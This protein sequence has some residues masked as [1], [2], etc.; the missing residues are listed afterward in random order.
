ME[1]LRQIDTLEER[2]GPTALVMSLRG[3]ALLGIEQPAP[4]ADA[5]ARALDIA[6]RDVACHQG[7]ARARRALGEIARARKHE[8]SAALFAGQRSLRSTVVPR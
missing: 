5:F 2:L 7:R 6:P 4:A 1:A 3:Y 8:Q